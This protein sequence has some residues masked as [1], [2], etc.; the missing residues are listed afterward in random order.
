MERYWM[1]WVG[2]LLALAALTGCM[3][4]DSTSIALPAGLPNAVL[5]GCAEATVRELHRADEQWNVRITRRDVTRGRF[6]TGDFHE[7]NVMGYRLRVV[8]DGGA[9]RA[10]LSVR[11]AGPYFT[12]LGAKRALSSVRTRL[13]TCIARAAH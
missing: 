3:P 5:V 10:T 12:D 7:A 8:R 11:A 13:A 9:P 4:Q 2:A 6:E 1:R